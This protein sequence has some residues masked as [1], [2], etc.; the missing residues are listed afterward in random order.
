MFMFM[1]NKLVCDQPPATHNEVKEKNEGSP[2]SRP[3]ARLRVV[4][5]LT[6]VACAVRGPG[7][8]PSRRAQ[9]AHAHTDTGRESFVFSRHV[10]AL[11]ALAPWGAVGA[12]L[13][14]RFV[15]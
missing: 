6:L 1:C 2:L 15:R 4:R 3:S 12:P 14:V 9:P 8:P 10:A 13:A 11:S 5:V 7:P